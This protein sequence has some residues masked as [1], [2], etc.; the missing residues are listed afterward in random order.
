MCGHTSGKCN[1][2]LKKIILLS[3]REI[4]FQNKFS[5]PSYFSSYER[6]SVALWLA[7]CKKKLHFSFDFSRVFLITQLRCDARSHPFLVAEKVSAG[8]A[9]GAYEH[10]QIGKSEL[11]GCKT[12]GRRRWWRCANNK[13]RPHNSH[14]VPQRG[15]EEKQ[16]GMGGC[17]SFLSQRWGDIST[18]TAILSIPLSLRRTV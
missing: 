5:I 4:Y 17:L 6:I 14:H 1:R 3:P 12:E 10:S 18:T 13:N 2:R 7:G 15:V 9:A 16:K 11:G 8:C